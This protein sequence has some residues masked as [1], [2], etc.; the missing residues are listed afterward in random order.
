[1]YPTREAEKQTAALTDRKK[2]VLD[3]DISSGCGSS[4]G[5]ETHFSWA[6]GILPEGGGI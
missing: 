4:G 2:Y 3:G 5:G 6:E 1:M